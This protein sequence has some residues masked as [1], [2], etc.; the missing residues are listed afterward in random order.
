MEPVSKPALDP[1]IAWYLSAKIREFSTSLAKVKNPPSRLNFFIMGGIG[2]GKSSLLNTMFSSVDVR[3]VKLAAAMPLGGAHVTTIFSIRDLTPNIHIYDGIGFTATN[4]QKR[5]FEY[6]LK[7]RLKNNFNFE[8]G[9]IDE[10]LRPVE[11]SKQY[12]VHCVIFLIPVA[13]ADN[14]VYITRMKQFM[15]DAEKIGVKSIIV[16]S[17]VDKVV[18]QLRASPQFIFDE[19]KIQTIIKETAARLGVDPFMIVP[20]MNYVVEQHKDEQIDI[21][22]LRILELAIAVSE[23]NLV[24]KEKSQKWK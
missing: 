18:P 20:G 15:K 17:Q 16:L 1:S 14:N 21:A 24:E 10:W 2:A 12:E 4:Y 22:A 5:E 8:T 9:D 23:D 3:V 13:S 11:E 7:G 6:I 19:S